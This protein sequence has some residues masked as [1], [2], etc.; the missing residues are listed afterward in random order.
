MILIDPWLALIAAAFAI[1]G[2]ERA[3]VDVVRYID[4]RAGHKPKGPTGFV[5]PR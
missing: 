2:I 4:R 3:L 1:Y 5:P